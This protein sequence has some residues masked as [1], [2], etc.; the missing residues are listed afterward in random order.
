[1]FARL[2]G[3]L[4]NHSN[5]QLYSH[6]EHSNINNLSTNMEKQSLTG[7]VSLICFW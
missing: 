6:D 7:T 1:L 2:S 3:N 4:K 5:A